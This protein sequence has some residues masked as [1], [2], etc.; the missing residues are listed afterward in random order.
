MGVLSVR[1]IVYL[2]S[3]MI[4]IF[5]VCLQSIL[6]L[7]LWPFKKKLKLAYRYHKMMKARYYWRGSI[8]LIIESFF[9]LCVGILLSFSEP[10]FDNPSDIFDFTLTC[11]FSLIVI[12]API[13][14]LLLHYKYSKELHED[15]FQK[16]FGSLTEGYY[17]TGAL[18]KA[19]TVKMIIWY[20]VRRILTAVALVH[21]SN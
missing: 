20:F 1:F 9:D 17:T 21:L 2:G 15:W 16:R 8:R 19:S 3:F 13:T 14:S 6:F 4:A 11:L 12:A 18:G 5:L 10:S 7:I